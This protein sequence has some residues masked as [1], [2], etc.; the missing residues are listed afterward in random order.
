MASPPLWH[1]PRNVRVWGPHGPN[2]PVF[3][4]V[5]AWESPWQPYT[6]M[7]ALV[8]ENISNWCRVGHLLWVGGIFEKYGCAHPLWAMFTPT[9]FKNA[10]NPQQVAHTAPI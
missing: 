7:K 9:F 3:T 8:E 2:F 10:T 1:T 4:L 5:T 6:Q